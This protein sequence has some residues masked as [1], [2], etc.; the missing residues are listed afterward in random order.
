MTLSGCVS[1]ESTRVKRLDNTT[2]PFSVSPV[3]AAT[4][5]TADD[6]TLPFSANASMKSSFSRPTV[7]PASIAISESEGSLRCLP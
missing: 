5:W 1:G 4:R 3:S 2:L 7:S 6:D